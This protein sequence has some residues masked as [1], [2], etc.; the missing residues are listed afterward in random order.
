MLSRV[1]APRV[2]ASAAVVT[3]NTA[4]SR[5]PV[6]THHGAPIKAAIVG[7][8]PT[9]S[10]Q[11][12]SAAVPTTNDAVAARSGC[13]MTR[14]SCELTPACVAIRAPDRKTAAKNNQIMTVG[15]E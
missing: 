8:F 2:G 10:E 5:P 15:G 6:H 9:P 12:A 3:T 11:T 7:Q 13:P 4:P 14:A 1:A